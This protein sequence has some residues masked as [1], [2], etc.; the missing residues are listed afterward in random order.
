M[1]EGP[2]AE[3]K[4]GLP[5]RERKQ[6]PASLTASRLLDH[7]D[8]WYASPDQKASIRRVVEW[9]RDCAESEPSR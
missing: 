7:Q 2:M 8:R 6:H 9:L 4:D 1:Q 3:R 5:K